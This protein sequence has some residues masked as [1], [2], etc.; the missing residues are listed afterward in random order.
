MIIMKWTQ[1]IEEQVHIVFSQIMNEVS[2]ILRR[3]DTET[4]NAH[5]ILI[6]LTI[7]SYNE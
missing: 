1:S 2:K 6:T 7:Y 4:C 5:I 3:V